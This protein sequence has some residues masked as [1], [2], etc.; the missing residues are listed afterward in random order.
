MLNNHLSEIYLLLI[1]SKNRLSLEGTN[2]QS[3]M[4]FSRRTIYVPP[5][6][7]ISMY[8]IKTYFLIFLYW[9]RVQPHLF[10][11]FSLHSE[12]KSTISFG[13][14]LKMTYFWCFYLSDFTKTSVEFKE[15]RI[16]SLIYQWRSLTMGSAPS[17][18]NNW[19]RL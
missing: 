15:T 3:N 13:N 14:H 19:L 16:K 1:F 9:V 6:L 7:C 8:D 5:H 18:I 10:F 4:M 12:L 11:N 17:P 2:C